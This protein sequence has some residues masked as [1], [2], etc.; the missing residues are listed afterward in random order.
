MLRTYC[1]TANQMLR[2]YVKVSVFDVNTCMSMV[3]DAKN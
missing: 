3:A 1:T 2:Y